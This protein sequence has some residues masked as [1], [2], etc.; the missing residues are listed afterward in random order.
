M[1]EV[2]RIHIAKISYDIEVVAKRD[3]E[4]YIKALEMYAD[5]KE[6]LQDIEIRITELLADRGVAKNYVITS[7]D[8]ASIREQLGD[9]KEFLADGKQVKSMIET[10]EVIDRKLY[11]NIDSAVLGGVLSGIASYFKV[12]SI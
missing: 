8:V 7:D 6:L 9:P 1:K 5:D 2:T 4:K 12:N 3:I 10:D 11:R